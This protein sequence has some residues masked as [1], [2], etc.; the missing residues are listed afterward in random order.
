[1]KILRRVASQES[2]KR[3]LSNGE[4][5]PFLP[6]GFLWEPS[7]SAANHSHESAK[8]IDIPLRPTE[9]DCLKTHHGIA[10]IHCT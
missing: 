3:L 7:G 6:R 10:R 4:A 8:R 2:G 9:V 5:P 1:M